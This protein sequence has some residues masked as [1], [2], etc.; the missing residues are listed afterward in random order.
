MSTQTPR[1]VA[2]DEGDHFHFLN[3]LFT[4][5]VTAEHTDGK[6][7]AMEFVAPKGFG[8]PLHR[9]DVED[10]LFYVAD[11]EVWFA[12]GEDEAV[13]RTGAVV[14]LPRGLPH[15]FQVLSDEARVFQ[16]STPSQFERFVATLG[17]PADDA[18]QPEPEDIDPEHVAAVC[19]QFDIAVLGPPP[20]PLA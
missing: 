8:P 3:H 5:K 7:T 15:Q 2:R 13:H 1:L 4:A 9:H 10:E 11:G 6:L 16:V 14:W 17:R 12:C 19:A 20:P 18:V